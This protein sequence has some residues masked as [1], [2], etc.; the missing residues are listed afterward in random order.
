MQK[1]IISELFGTK[2]KLKTTTM[3]DFFTS[4]VSIEGLVRSKLEYFKELIENDKEN[5]DVEESCKLVLLDAFTEVIYSVIFAGNEKDD[6]GDSFLEL[7]FP[8]LKTQSLD[9]QSITEY[10]LHIWT[11]ID[12]VKIMLFNYFGVIYCTHPIIIE[13]IEN[14]PTYLKNHPAS[15]L[16]NFCHVSLH[17]LLNKDRYF[18]TTTSNKVFLDFLNEKKITGVIVDNWIIYGLKAALPEFKKFLDK[19]Q[20]QYKI[21]EDW[22]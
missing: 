10:M 21:K 18:E 15:I 1:R 12:R 19:Y 16:E 14:S 17:I 3:L 4:N 13:A 7:C 11:D 9:S 8:V 5:Q 20:V 6:N 22:V 2:S